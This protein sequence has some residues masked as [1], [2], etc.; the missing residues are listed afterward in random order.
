M[1]RNVCIYINKHVHTK[2]DIWKDIRTTIQTKKQND[3][4]S[5]NPSTSSSH[6]DLRKNM[7]VYMLAAVWAKKRWT[8]L[9]LF[10]LQ[11]FQLNSCC[12]GKAIAQ[13]HWKTNCNI[14]YNIYHTR[15]FPTRRYFSRSTLRFVRATNPGKLILENFW[16]FGTRK[17]ELF[18]QQK[19]IRFRLDWAMGGSC[20]SCTEAWTK[21]HRSEM[22]FASSWSSASAPTKLAIRLLP[23]TVLRFRL[24]RMKLILRL[25]QPSRCPTHWW[26]YRFTQNCRC[27]K[28]SFNI[29]ENHYDDANDADDVDDDEI[30]D[31]RIEIIM[32][33]ILMFF[34]FHIRMC[35]INLRYAV[36]C[37]KA[38]WQVWYKWY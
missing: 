21:R 26:V 18:R 14:L 2:H 8:K 13:P 38:L 9:G 22:W 32:R 28:F 30:N 11:L 37:L 27:M 34:S 4:T 10:V 19:L 23:L 15:S 1:R 20:S 24:R 3:N 35:H 12:I 7:Y 16:G 25:V 6:L 17:D 33:M 29:I 31:T 36:S 5:S